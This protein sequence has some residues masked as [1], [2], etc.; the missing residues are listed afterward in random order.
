MFFLLLLSFKMEDQGPTHKSLFKTT[1]YG[2]WN[3]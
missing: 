3:D 1:D 2:A